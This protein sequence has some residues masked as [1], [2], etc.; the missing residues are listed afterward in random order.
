MTFCF[1]VVTPFFSSCCRINPGDNR[2]F[3]MVDDDDPSIST[4]M[5]DVG[6]VYEISISVV[7]DDVVP[8]TVV[9]VV[10]GSLLDAGVGVDVG[11]CDD[12][13]GGGSATTTA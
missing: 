1:D 5:G 9:A 13:D 11:S 12:D 6:C 10:A 3:E 2:R 8:A 4:T 7:A